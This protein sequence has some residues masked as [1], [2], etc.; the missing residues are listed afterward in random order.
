[1]ISVEAR[2][3]VDVRG[4]S[5]LLRR[6]IENILR[7]AIRYSPKG[8]TVEAGSRLQG[9]DAVISVRDYGPG[10]RGDLAAHIFDPFF[11]EDKSRN[12]GTGGLGLGLAIARRAIRVHHGDIKFENARP[13]ALFEIT[14]PA[15]RT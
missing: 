4:N 11:R 15:A 5:E 14:I 12:G 10:I 7:N 13:G 6:A 2:D 9:F 8:A 3:D 1:V